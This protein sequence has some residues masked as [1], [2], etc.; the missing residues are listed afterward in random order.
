M[1]FRLQGAFG[2][3]DLRCD[4]GREAGEDE[5]V[6]RT[7][8]DVKGTVFGFAGPAWAGGISVVGLHFHFL[9]DEVDGVRTGGCVVDF[10][11]G[12]GVV[13]DWAVCGR[14]HLGLPRGDEW[15]SL[16]LAA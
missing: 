16:E 10:V 6:L 14:F 11:A 4:G 8:R 7:V 5:A 12:E 15:E 1:P 9:G 13:L 2:K 3:V